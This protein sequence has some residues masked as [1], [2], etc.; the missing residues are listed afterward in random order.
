MQNYGKYLMSV[1]IIVL[2]PLVAWG[3]GKVKINPIKIDKVQLNNLKTMPISLAAD[4]CEVNHSGAPAYIITDWIIGDETYYNYLDPSQTCIAPYPFSVSSVYMVIDFDAPTSI[5]VIGEV[6]DVDLSNPSCAQPGAIIGTSATLNF[7]ILE[8]G[9]WLLP[10]P[11]DTLPIVNGPFFCGFNIVDTTDINVVV[12]AITDNSLDSCTSF[13]LWDSTAGAIDLNSFDPPF[14]G[15]LILYASGITGGAPDITIVTPAANQ[16]QFDGID[17]WAVETSGSTIIDNVFFKYRLNNIESP[18]YQDFDG[19]VTLRDGINPV[20]FNPGYYT[21][22][23][24]TALPFGPVDI[25][26]EISDTLGR[27]FTDEISVFLQ[28]SSP[29]PSFISPAN[30]DFFCSPLQISSQ[31]PLSGMIRVDYYL[32]ESQADYS[33]ALTPVSLISFGTYYEAPIAVAQMSQVWADRGFPTLMIIGPDTLNIISL[34]EHYAA[35]FD[36]LNLTGSKDDLINLTLYDFVDLKNGAIT[37]QVF[38]NPDYFTLR[39][40]IEE[41]EQTGMLALSGSVGTWVA[42]DG[43]SGG[44]QPDNSFN[45]LVHDPIS[46]SIIEAPYRTNGAVNE[47]YL[48]NNWLTVDM[49]ITLGVSDHEVTRRLIGQDNSSADGWSLSFQPDS[50]IDKTSYFIRAEGLDQATFKKAS[51][52]LINYDCSQIYTTGDYDGDS[53]AN[54]ADATYLVNYIFNGGPAPIGE[55]WRGDSNCDGSLNNTDVVFYANYLFGSAVLCN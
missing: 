24:F 50:L 20:V 30:E 28:P 14:P 46:G 52:I 21:P 39:T 43:F 23:D 47:I 42:I 4:S 49:M 51:T 27:T 35:A 26:A 45:V 16:P 36:V 15:Q 9:M 17:I 34:T 38:R 31:A 25:L 55:A 33:C 12:S 18:I 5:S 10:V 3:N 41:Q 54:I 44:R 2:L 6:L 53:F 19:N 48:Y 8:A 40:V 13:N 29:M 7:D 22:W 11:F 1:I 37:S 32:K